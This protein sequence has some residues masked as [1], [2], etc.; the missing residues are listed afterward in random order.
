MRV[1]HHGAHLVRVTQILACEQGARLGGAGGA[2]T[3]RGPYS[4]GRVARCGGR[5]AGRAAAGPREAARAARLR[6]GRSTS[7]MSTSSSESAS[8]TTRRARRSHCRRA[9]VERLGAGHSRDH[10][11]AGERVRQLDGELEHRLG[12]QVGLASAARGPR[13]RASARR[14]ERCGGVDARVAHEQRPRH[15]SRRPPR[16]SRSERRDD[17]DAAQCGS[18][19]GTMQ[20][21][22][23]VAHELC[24]AARAPSRRRAE[25]TRRRAARRIRR[26]ASTRPGGFD[27]GARSSSA[28]SRTRMLDR[29]DLHGRSRSTCAMCCVHAPHDARSRSTA[30]RNRPPTRSRASSGRAGAFLRP[31][32]S[33]PRA[34]S[35]PLARALALR[36]PSSGSFGLGRALG[37][38]ADAPWPASGVDHDHRRAAWRALLAGRVELAVLRQRIARLRT[39][40]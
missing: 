8:A 16:P 3:G 29:C 33:W 39:R 38:D 20:K 21:A 18:T 4:D 5:G 23:D 22:G 15:P 37:V 40:S 7:A 1:R 32:A 19:L 2:R 13:P 11:H 27:E 36:P 30:A 6:K 17:R 10:E 34:S 35:A 28:V 9:R 26:H 14:R 31:P 24:R 12:L 25:A